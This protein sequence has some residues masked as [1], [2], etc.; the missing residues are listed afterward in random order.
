MSFN[1]FFAKEKKT[2]TYSEIVKVLKKAASKEGTEVLRK[3]ISAVCKDREK[4]DDELKRFNKI[5]KA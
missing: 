2:E 5:I 3:W 4:V 1:E